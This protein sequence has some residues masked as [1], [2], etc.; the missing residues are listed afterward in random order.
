[1]YHHR[2]IQKVEW[3]KYNAYEEVANTVCKSLVILKL[4]IG[5]YIWNT[6]GENIIITLEFQHTKGYKVYILV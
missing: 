1:M 3:T 2:N 4:I 6:Y 5:S